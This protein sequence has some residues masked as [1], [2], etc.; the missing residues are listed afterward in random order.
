VEVQKAITPAVDFTQWHE[1]RVDWL[2]DKIT[3]Y[4]DGTPWTAPP[5]KD[6]VSMLPSTSTMG[7]ALQFDTCSPKQYQDWIPC[8]NVVKPQALYVDWV[9]V[10]PYVP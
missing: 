10:R 6:G 5:G 8:T 9:K 1:V 7:F 4:L 3:F 2:P